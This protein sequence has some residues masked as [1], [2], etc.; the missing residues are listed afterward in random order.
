M[1]KIYIIE[2]TKEVMKK[3]E[4]LIPL[5]RRGQKF[6]YKKL[7]KN[8]NIFFHLLINGINS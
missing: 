8:Y 4:E 7:L 1:A 2:G 3:N 5:I 6:I